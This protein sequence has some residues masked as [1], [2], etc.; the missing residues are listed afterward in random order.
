[1]RDLF[2]YILTPSEGGWLLH[3][4]TMDDGYGFHHHR[5]HAVSSDLGWLVILVLLMI[6]VLGVMI[7][8]STMEFDDRRPARVYPDPPPGPAQIP[9]GI[10]AAGTGG[11]PHGMAQQIDVSNFFKRR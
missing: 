4:T 10:P 7:F 5:H 1:M 11:I 9:Y 6:V 8:L 2:V 3:Y